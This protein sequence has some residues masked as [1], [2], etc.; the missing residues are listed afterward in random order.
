MD[1]REAWLRGASSSCVF[2][3]TMPI[4]ALHMCIWHSRPK[5]ARC[6]DLTGGERMEFMNLFIPSGLQRLVC[7]CP[8][9]SCMLV[10][11]WSAHGH[12]G[13]LGWSQDGLERGYIHLCTSL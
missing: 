1:A 6:F 2:C 8:S 11:S 12:L 5:L 9:G 10:V 13:Y 3:V 4:R 7:D